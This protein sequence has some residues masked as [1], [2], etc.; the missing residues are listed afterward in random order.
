MTQLWEISQ[1]EI[2]PSL[3]YIKDWRCEA[4]T[5][6]AMACQQ[7]DYLQ[8]TSAIRSISA[9][10][11]ETEVVEDLDSMENGLNEYQRVFSL[12]QESKDIRMEMERTPR[13]YLN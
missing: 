6:H 11:T 13:K 8:L 1:D 4:Q 5:Y 3:L 7:G 9:E 10:T 2:V 12:I